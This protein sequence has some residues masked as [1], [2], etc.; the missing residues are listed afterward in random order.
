MFKDEYKT[1]CGLTNLLIPPLTLHLKSSFENFGS[2]GCQSHENAIISQTIVNGFCKTE[3]L[4]PGEQVESDN[5]CYNIR[6]AIK[7]TGKVTEVSNIN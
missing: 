1:T 4:P 6:M 5:D 7:E 2:N 3:I